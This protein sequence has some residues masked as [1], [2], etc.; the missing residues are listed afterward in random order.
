MR[1][2]RKFTLLLGAL[3]LSIV[4]TTPKASEAATCADFCR[5]QDRECRTACGTWRLCLAGCSEDYEQCIYLC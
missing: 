1:I 5:Q 3:A 4:V 2:A